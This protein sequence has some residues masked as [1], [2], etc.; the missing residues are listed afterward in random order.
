MLVLP[1][2]VL[3]RPFVLPLLVRFLA[4]SVFTIS[5]ATPVVTIP[6][7]ALAPL[8]AQLADDDAESLPEFALKLAKLACLV[9]YGLV[10]RWYQR[11]SVSFTGC[12]FWLL[13]TLG[14]VLLALLDPKVDLALLLCRDHFLGLRAGRLLLLLL[15]LAF[16]SL[17]ALA[18]L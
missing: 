1:S 10:C 5:L 4:L 12:F 13:V 3:L 11:S 14:E 9:L 16:T 15:A 7:P 18:R 8:L 2:L 17:R 6:I